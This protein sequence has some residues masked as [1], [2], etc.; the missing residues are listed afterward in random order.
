[1]GWLKSKSI[2]WS[3]VISYA[4]LLAFAMFVISVICISTYNIAKKTVSEF[5]DYTFNQ[6]KIEI[7]NINAELEEVC[8]NIRFNRNLSDAFRNEKLNSSN[9]PYNYMMIRKD[10]EQYV[11]VLM[12]YIKLQLKRKR[13]LQKRFI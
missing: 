9:L 7:D 8:T 3:W 12:K 11:F 4:L 10:M 6:M 5:N 2:V 13:L 1:M